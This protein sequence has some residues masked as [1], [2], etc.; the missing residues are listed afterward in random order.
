[1]TA[2]SSILTAN[3]VTLRRWDWE[4]ETKSGQLALLKHEAFGG[5]VW[6][7]RNLPSVYLHISSA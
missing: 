2:K 1:V 3:S 6:L 5:S 7:P 4:Q